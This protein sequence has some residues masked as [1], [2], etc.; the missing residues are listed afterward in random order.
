M[1]LTNTFP[2]FADLDNKFLKSIATFYQVPIEVLYLT[3]LSHREIRKCNEVL[4]HDSGSLKLKDSKEALRPYKYWLYSLDVNE[5]LGEK[6]NYKETT[7][8]C[9]VLFWKS[10]TSIIPQH[11]SS[12]ATYLPSHKLIN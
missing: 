1:K 2:L 9:C 6:K 10:R 5:A 8:R 3:I 4:L 11:S 7:Q 12:V